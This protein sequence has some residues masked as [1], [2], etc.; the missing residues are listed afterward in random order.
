MAWQALAS[1][2]GYLLR[3]TWSTVE[4]AA[5]V[6]V[7]GTLLGLTLGLLRV[8]PLPPLQRVVAGVVEFIR[9]VP[10]LLQMFFI[11]F[12]L[13]AFGV[14]IPV[15]LSAV[16][17]ITLWMGVNSAEVV[18]GAI[19]S[20]PHGQTEAAYSTG[21]G[22]WQTMRWIV[23][24]QAFRRMLP[25]FV[26]LCTILIKDTSLAAIIGVF[27]LTRAAQETIERTFQSFEIYLVVAAVYFALCFPLTTLSRALERRLAAPGL[28]N[29]FAAE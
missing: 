20:I 17:A 15:F 3:G 9:A 21:L 10:L 25:P 22:Y 4:L 19:Q 7:T 12:G 13:P 6:L 14:E 29:L 28:R 27:E 8:V 5:T 11:F 23:C 26:G 1:S 16:M 24:P 18:R 2:L